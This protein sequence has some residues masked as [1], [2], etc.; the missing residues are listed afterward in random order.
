MG[1][2][3]SGPI[4]PINAA[5]AAATGALLGAT[6]AL[7]LGVGANASAAIAV[8]GAALVALIAH[9][10][11]SPSERAFVLRAALAAFA[12]RA[13]VGAVLHTVSVAMGR[14]GAVTGDDRAYADLAWAYVRYVNG[15][16][17]PPDVPPYW[18]GQE[19]L[20]GTFVYLESAVFQVVGRD[21]LAMQLINGALASLGHVALFDV[22]RR[23]FG[24]TSAR[25]AIVLA[26][27]Y[28]S[29]I[30]WS[31]LNLKEAYVVTAV[32]TVLWSLVRL[33]S[34][35]GGW[36]SLAISYV[37]IQSLESMRAYSFL[38][39]LFVVPVSILLA[40]GLPMA[41]RVRLV[42]VAVSLSWL[43]LAFSPLLPFATDLGYALENLDIVRRAQA[44]SA[45]TAF[46]EPR[47]FP[48]AVGETLYV[49]TAEPTVSI[50]TD[51]SKP[52]TGPAA[53]PP[54]DPPLT[55]SPPTTYYVKPGT[56]IVLAETPSPT[57]RPAAIAPT[58][59]PSGT[60]TPAQTPLV[61]VVDGPVVTVRPGDIVIVGSRDTTPAPEAQRRRIT[62]VD[63]RGG[64]EST[65]LDVPVPP[66]TEPEALV[67]RRTLE[68]APTGLVHALFAPFPW[69][70][71]RPSEAPLAAEMLVWYA[72]LA[73]AV[74]TVARHR[75]EW[76]R[77]APILIYT[78]GVLAIFSLVEGNIGTLHRHR[79]MLVPYV[80]MLASPGVIALGESIGRARASRRRA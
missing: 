42:A 50:S 58:P 75:S 80:V 52:P 32:T 65:T 12:L 22:A 39:L 14:G 63:Q 49:P 56:R 5:V 45:R 60:L 46:V 48:V 64:T 28:P 26:A 38:G 29:L 79:S 24:S 35:V 61:V 71:R 62:F 78:G 47:P 19:Y 34:P 21:M 10:T 25:V 69:N 73:G 13:A 66:R 72:L 18:G 51:P 43:L 53:S 30:L 54:A 44:E 15:D 57:P 70:V 8:L 59:T 37:I 11:S 31:S 16:P 7:A 74:W 4:S 6:I 2:L 33:G 36:V 17:Q 76:R 40:H 1:L 68:H 77:L 67:L 3:R 27:V 20:F 41:R 9:R 23:L 55:S